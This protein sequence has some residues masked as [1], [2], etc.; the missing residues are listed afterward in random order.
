MTLDAALTLFTNFEKVAELCD[1]RDDLLLPALLHV[2]M[3][4]VAV[5]TS[6]N[7]PLSQ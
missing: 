5:L 7:N 4:A 6:L 2:T 3:R 1:Q